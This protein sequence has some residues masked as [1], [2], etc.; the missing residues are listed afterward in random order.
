MSVFARVVGEI[1]AVPGGLNSRLL[2]ISFKVRY[3]V[4]SPES[5]ATG[6]ASKVV[7]R[8]PQG[9][10]VSLCHRDGEKHY[11]KLWRFQTRVTCQ[12]MAIAC[13]G[14]VPRYG[15]CRVI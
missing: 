9:W 8:M 6:L 15:G 4:S 13:M 11:A 5:H 1:L 14:I 7:S 10:R 2:F 3:V 12:I